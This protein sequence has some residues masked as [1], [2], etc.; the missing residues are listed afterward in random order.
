VRIEPEVINLKS[1]GDFTIFIE[2]EFKEGHSVNDIEPT[3]LKCFGATAQSFTISSDNKMVVKFDRRNL[4]NVPVGDH[5]V[6]T[7]TGSFKNNGPSFMG[8]DEVCVTKG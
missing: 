2:M 7:V 8:Y 4:Q 1:N 6:F 3:S 5:V